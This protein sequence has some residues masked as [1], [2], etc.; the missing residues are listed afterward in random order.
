MIH[1]PRPRS[2]RF[3]MPRLGKA[4]LTLG[5]LLAVLAS[6]AVVFGLF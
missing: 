1:P 6:A 5:A 4:A 3:A 2:D